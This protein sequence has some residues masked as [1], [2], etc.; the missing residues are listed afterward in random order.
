MRCSAQ[1]VKQ[2]LERGNRVIA[3]VRTDEAASTLKELGANVTVVMMD[4]TDSES[5][6]RF[7]QTVRDKTE[8]VDVS[9]CTTRSARGSHVLPFTPPLL[10]LSRYLILHIC[11]DAIT[12]LMLPVCAGSTL[13]N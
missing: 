2:F 13:W 8:H 7:A 10:S 9:F 6:D 11:S 3:T 12:S 4:V 1:F 5:I